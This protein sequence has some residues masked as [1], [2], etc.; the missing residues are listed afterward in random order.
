MKK[1]IASVLLASASIPALAWGDREQGIL[2]GI[3]GTI[4]LQNL[5]RGDV[6]L[7]VSPQVA[8]PYQP[9]VQPYYYDR[10]RHHNR[11]HRYYD[12]RP[13]HRPH[14]CNWVTDRQIDRY[15][16][17]YYIERQICR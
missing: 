13:Y 2:T 7:Q 1:L 9:Y 6:N 16:N 5:S 14:G 3:A 8:I 11:G 4:L 10:H 17:M 15:G 12:E